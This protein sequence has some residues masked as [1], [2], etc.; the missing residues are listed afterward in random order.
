TNWPMPI[1][2]VSPSP[3]M[4]MAISFLFAS[5][6]PVPTDGMR[7]WTALKPCE[8]PR[9]YARLL[10]EQPRA[11][12]DCGGL[13]RVAA[14]ARQLDALVRIDAHLVECLDDALRDRVLAAAGTQR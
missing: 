6:A 8:P 2:P 3:L 12:A 9:K 1:A 11:A 14:D 7:P 13:L 4:P 5:M 10:L